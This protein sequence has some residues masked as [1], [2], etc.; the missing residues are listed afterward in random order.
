VTIGR[1]VLTA[2]RQAVIAHRPL[3]CGF[4]EC[5]ICDDGDDYASEF[6]WE[7]N[8][9]DSRALLSTASTEHVITFAR[10]AREDDDAY[11]D[12]VVWAWHRTIG[13]VPQKVSGNGLVYAETIDRAIAGYE[14]EFPAETNADL[15]DWEAYV[16]GVNNAI[17]KD[18]LAGFL[19]TIDPHLVHTRPGQPGGTPSEWAIDGDD[20]DV[21]YGGDEGSEDIG[22]DATHNVTV[23]FTPDGY[24]PHS[25]YIQVRASHAP[26]EKCDHS[27]CEHSKIYFKGGS[28]TLEWIGNEEEL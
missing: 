7:V 19:R 2:R 9:D 10:E 11:E 22:G 20:S 17:K 26:Q 1:T 4:G 5:A 14:E 8:E 12:E 23:Q 15:V 25:C 24:T 18:G 13:T 28:Y 6:Q 16:S 27:D 21:G 3:D